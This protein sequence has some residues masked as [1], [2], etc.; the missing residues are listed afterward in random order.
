MK[1][2]FLSALGMAA[3][4]AMLWADP[5][6]MV[7]RLSY[8][9]GSVSFAPSAG[10]AWGT[11]TLNY[12]LAAGNQLS[13]APGSRAEVQI[14]STD[15]LLASDTG[16]TFEALD[17]QAVEIRLDRGRA[18]FQLRYL[19]PDQDFQV[20]TPTARVT[21]SAP[22]EYRIDQ[23]ESGNAKVISWNGEAQVSGGQA[24]L[25]QNAGPRTSFTVGTGEEADIPSAGVQSY[26][27]TDAPQPDLWDQWVSDRV[28]RE[29]QY[30]STQYVSGQMDGAADLSEYG[31][32]T[33]AAGYGPV[34]FPSM[35]A[36]G[37]APYTMG[38]WVWIEPWG[39]TWVDDEPWG[40]AP[41]HYGR[42]AMIS[43][44][45]CWVPGPLVA[46]PVY[47]PAL[48]R[49]VGGA[50]WRGHPPGAVGVTWVPL[51]PREAFHPWYHASTTY[52][53]AVN[54]PVF[55]PRYGPRPVFASRS[56]FAPA[57]RAPA[58]FA[59][60]PF[61]PRPFAP[62]PFAPTPLA[63]RPSF[64]ERRPWFPG[65]FFAPR[66]PVVG[67]PGPVGEPGPAARPWPAGRPGPAAGQ[68]RRW[69]PDNGPASNGND[70]SLSWNQHGDR[71]HR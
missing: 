36:V 61:A 47:A 18:S 6:A 56:P 3:L 63:P 51:G 7:G 67:R 44:S 21:L 69:P 38:H 35:V 14:G 24:A 37:W 34:W 48:V 15:V 64:A 40:F 39:W 62:R 1:R 4:S 45:W 65:S 55:A 25:A 22:G 70:P 27:I 17:N 28:D 68:A 8:V 19:G 71:P 9:E 57:L 23:S 43:G 33:V 5:P 58:P 50:P 20:D 41:F 49:W 12:P 59:P 52:Y 31:T 29:D 16:I 30:A 2:I 53:R 46:H 42:W 60:R 13:T 54:R 66:P 11:A 26:Q 10:A 32:W